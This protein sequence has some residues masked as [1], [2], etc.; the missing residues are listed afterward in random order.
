MI[1]SHE[2]TLQIK[3]VTFGTIGEKAHTL[4]AQS[5]MCNKRLYQRLSH[6]MPF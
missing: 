5:G 2:A 3:R 4:K 1:Y 6:V